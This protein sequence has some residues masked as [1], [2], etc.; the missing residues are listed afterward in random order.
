MSS[1]TFCCA[2]ATSQ[3]VGWK[4]LPPAHSAICTR[5]AQGLLHQVEAPIALQCSPK[6]ADW[7]LFP[8]EQG[9]GARVLYSPAEP[10]ELSIDTASATADTQ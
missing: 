3:Q 10:E 4:V 9:D 5:F 2:Q 1:S 8:G 7:G 6:D